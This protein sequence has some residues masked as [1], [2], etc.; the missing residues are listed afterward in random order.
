M[1]KLS[2]QEL[3]DRMADAISEME[4]FKSGKSRVAVEQANPGNIRAWRTAQGEMYPRRRGYVDFVRFCGGDYEKGLAE[5]W[6]VLKVLI[7]RYLEG[8]YTNKKSP[9]FREM[10]HAYAPKS[11]NNNP[12]GYAE[13]VARKFG[14]TADTR[15][16]DLLD[17]EQERNRILAKTDPRGYKRRDG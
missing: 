2:K 3:I 12:D 11:D 16:V 6:R 1:T 4:G 13:F 8:R 5:G 15:I 17:D 10:F 14:V 7:E 9:T